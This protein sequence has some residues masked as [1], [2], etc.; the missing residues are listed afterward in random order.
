MALLM[1]TP[2]VPFNIP[3]RERIFIFQNF[4]KVIAKTNIIYV[5]LSFLEN[6]S[7][8]QNGESK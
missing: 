7:T 4:C 2:S 5:T 1:S 3:D 6:Y 8:V